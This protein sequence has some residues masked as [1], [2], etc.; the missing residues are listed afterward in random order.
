MAQ[1]GNYLYKR[2]RYTGWGNRKR[3]KTATE[4]HPGSDDL[5]L[6]LNLITQGQDQ[7]KLWSGSPCS[8]GLRP[9]MWQART[10]GK[11]PFT[12]SLWC[13]HLAFPIHETK[14]VECE[15]VG[16]MSLEEFWSLE[17]KASTETNQNL[18]SPR[19][20]LQDSLHLGLS[21]YSDLH[22]F[23]SQPIGQ[24]WILPRFKVS[25]GHFLVFV[26]EYP[27]LGGPWTLLGQ[28]WYYFL[29]IW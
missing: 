18:L 17:V 10:E 15:D 12:P 23:H 19:G 6:D 24:G 27:L 7:M 26:I 29:N 28:G 16:Q 2:P 21:C 3:R 13:G 5:G 14:G 11:D 1:Q 20:F 22:S 4:P 9:L 25:M 8:L